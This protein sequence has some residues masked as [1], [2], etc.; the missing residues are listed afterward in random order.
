FYKEC[1]SALKE[2]LIEQNKQNLEEVLED[3]IKY[4][5]A[6]LSKPFIADDLTIELNYN[7]QDFWKNA[8]IGLKTK[9]IKR[10]IQIKI[11]RKARYYGDLNDW[12]RE[13]VWWGN[14]RG[15][16]LYD[17]EPYGDSCNLAGHY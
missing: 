2:L 11:N 6:L 4:N 16:Y 10:P 7:L 1:L 17:S 12:C 15:A 3:S 8:R 13:V 14:K 5:Q 9:L